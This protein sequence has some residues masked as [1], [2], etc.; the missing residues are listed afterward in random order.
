MSAERRFVVLEAASGFRPEA[1]S[2]VNG[3]PTFRAPTPTRASRRPAS[4]SMRLELLVAEA[5]PAIAEL[6]A[7]PR[8]LVLPEVEH[9]HAAA[10]DRD[11][12]RLGHGVG[13]VRRVVQ[14]LRQQRHVDGRILNRQL[15][16]LAALPDDVA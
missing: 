10:G 3:S 6:G 15:L 7:D 2:T 8:F 9:D 16:E 5:E 4:V 11:A 12:R 13:R 1:I 14:R